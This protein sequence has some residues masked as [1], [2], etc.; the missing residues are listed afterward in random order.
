M[1]F[2]PA[3]M[4][5]AFLIIAVLAGC[6]MSPRH[7]FDPETDFDAFREFTFRMP[8]YADEKVSDPIL[9]SP[10]L[11]NRVREAVTAELSRRGYSVNDENPD[12]IVTYHAA[13]DFDVRDTGP[14]FNVGFYRGWN[15]IHTGV[16][17]DSWPRV[18]KE[19]VLIIDIIDAETGTLTWRGWRELPLNQRNFDSEQVRRS[20]A[21]ILSAFP[22]GQD[23]RR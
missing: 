4:F 21:N 16:L 13:K 1:K 6:A 15:H 9:D 3:S 19:G 8:E 11:G 22:P 5:S 12:F 17:F 20:A 23:D 10:L 7:E 14:R 18:S 2:R